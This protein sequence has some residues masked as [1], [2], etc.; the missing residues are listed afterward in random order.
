MECEV[1]FFGGI[2]RI[3]DQ[4]TAVMLR[5]EGDTLGELLEAVKTRWPQTAEFVGGEHSGSIILVLNE[6][7]LAGVDP[8]IK[9]CNGDR[10]TFMPMIAGG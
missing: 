2:S 6:R 5:F 3:A 7:A 9:L 10:L 4:H 8:D 1:R